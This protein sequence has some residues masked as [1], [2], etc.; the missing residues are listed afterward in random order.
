MAT[1]IEQEH[2]TETTRCVLTIIDNQE[3][4]AFLCVLSLHHPILQLQF[5]Y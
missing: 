5:F 4:L 3:F 1:L 2:L